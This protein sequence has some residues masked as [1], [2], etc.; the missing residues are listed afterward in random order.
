MMRLVAPLALLL[1]LAACGLQPMYAGGAS[2]ALAS[3]LA[4]VQVAPIS[5]NEGWLVTNA[6]EDRLGA[7]R[8]VPAARS[9]G[10]TWCWTI[11]SKGSAC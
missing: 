6:L 10:L 11:G 5:G 9:T 4:Q 8:R 7:G 1:T 2:G 3:G